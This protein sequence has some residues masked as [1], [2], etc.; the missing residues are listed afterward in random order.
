MKED[1]SSHPPGAKPED[2]LTERV[3]GLS[4]AKRALLELKLNQKDSGESRKR[5]I[6]RRAER[7]SAP[8]SFAQERLWFLEQLEPDA[9]AYNRPA[10]LRLTGILDVQALK[11]SLNEIVRRHEALRTA[12]VVSDD[13]PVQIIG[14]PRPLE[15]P[16]IDL[17]HLPK[18]EREARAMQLSRN[19]HHRRYSKEATC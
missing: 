10:G 11:Q 17:T 3:A 13:S 12:F 9:T 19:S 4:P 14:P 5:A 15:V 16:L 8:L 1:V 6:P 2:E 7:D 18:T